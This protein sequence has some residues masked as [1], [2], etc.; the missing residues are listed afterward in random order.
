MLPHGIGL[1][2]H[3]DALAS[4]A[5]DEAFIDPRNWLGTGGPADRPWLPSSLKGLEILC[6]AAGGGKHGPLYAAAGAKVTVVD[7]SAAMLE[8][9]RQVARERKLHLEL[10]Q[11]SMDDLAM[12]KND[13][14]DLV[15][16]PVS[17]CYLPSLKQLFF[18]IARVCRP[19]GL[20]MSQHKSP[21][22][23]QSSLQPN[24]DGRY[25]VLFPEHRSAESSKALPP[26]PP[27]RLREVGTDEFV[28]S[29]TDILGGICRSGFCLED[30]FEPSEGDP[31][32]TRG[33]FAHR[34]AF[35][36]PYIRVLA[37]KYGQGA[38]LQPI[39]V[40]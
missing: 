28:H 34:A 5:C 19:G 27:S 26:A 2:K 17:S 14:F 7:L 1:P 10:I 35:L 4:P 24:L 21:R 31:E 30:F 3:N 8:L 6:L 20:Y 39:V 13:R 15:I 12:L 29:L 37:R 38:T 18:E 40:Q 23:L 9:D 11:S 36:P 33:S 22:N 16:H 25:E 32:A